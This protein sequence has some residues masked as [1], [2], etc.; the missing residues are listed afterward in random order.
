MTTD[1]FIYELSTEVHPKIGQWA[2]EL[3]E[4]KG[5]TISEVKEAMQRM[6]DICQRD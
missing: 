2:R 3:I 1:E 5:M 6:I 4:E